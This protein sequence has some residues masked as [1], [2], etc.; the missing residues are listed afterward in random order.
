MAETLTR[1]D[2]ELCSLGLGNMESLIHAPAN[3]FVGNA[4]S[5]DILRL[6]QSG[7]VGV[8]G[9]I[10]WDKQ[11]GEGSKRELHIANVGDCAAVLVSADK[12]GERC[13]LNYVYK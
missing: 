1:L 10:S 5:H 7:A 13:L 11:H 6:A 12:S 3:P 2:S 9:Q 4:V 8:F